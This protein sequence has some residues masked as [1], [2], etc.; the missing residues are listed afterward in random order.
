MMHTIGPIPLITVHRA[1]SLRRGQSLRQSTFEIPAVPPS[2]RPHITNHPPHRSPLIQLGGPTTNNPVTTRSLLSLKDASRQRLKTNSRQGSSSRSISS[3]VTPER[4]LIRSTRIGA[5][6]LQFAGE[7]SFL[8]PRMAL[9]LK[10]GYHW[11]WKDRPPRL[12]SPVLREESGRVQEQV[13]KLV[14]SGAIYEVQPQPCLVSRIFAIPK[15]PTGWRLILDV[16]DLNQLLVVPSF[17]MTNHRSLASLLQHPA[18]W[19]ASLDLK[20]AYMHVPIRPNLHKFLALTCWKKLFFFRSL[21]FGLAPAPWLFSALM[22]QALNQ[23]RKQGIQVLGYIDDLI[24]WHQDKDTLSAQVA[25]AMVFLDQLGL[26]INVEKS[27]PSPTS[28]LTWLGVVWHAD[29]GT[30]FPQQRLLQ[31]I[32]SAALALTIAPKSSRRS[33]ESLQGSIAFVAQINA[34]VEH[35]AHNLARLSCF[36][37][38]THRDVLVALPQK[39]KDQLPRWVRIEK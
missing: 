37:H 7:W 6:L 16:S 3:P 5:R 15:H 30:W 39:L 4:N 10:R 8:P 20:D 28:S 29:R 1:K 34:R 33:W 22:E 17:K 11:E 21:P 9:F 35:W 23:L 12:G 38:K 26:T 25:R 24:F 27:H 14:D 36:D 18:A 31:D 2:Q 19:V 13:Q 32:Q